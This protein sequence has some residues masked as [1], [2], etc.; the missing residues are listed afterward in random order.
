MPPG[1]ASTIQPSV[2]GSEPEAIVPRSARSCPARSAL[3]GHARASHASSSCSLRSFL[4]DRNKHCC[5]AWRVRPC[6]SS[7]R[8]AGPGAARQGQGGSFHSESRP[9]RNSSRRGSRRRGA[10]Q[11]P[12]APRT[13][14]N[15]QARS[16]DQHGTTPARIAAICLRVSERCGAVIFSQAPEIQIAN[17]SPRKIRWPL[18]SNRR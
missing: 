5:R 15:F 8:S 10:R 14:R 17:I 3:A 13:S 16:G 1:K 18:S 4:C 12:I 9:S 2:L 7:G 6:V 11:C